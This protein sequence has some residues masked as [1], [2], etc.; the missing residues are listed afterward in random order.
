[1]E[2]VLLLGRAEAGKLSFKPAAIAIV[3]FAMR[4]VDEIRSVTHDRC[5]LSLHHAGDLDGAVADEALL[6]HILSN[7]LSNAVKY[8]PET[9]P[10]SLKILRQG[11]SLVFQVIDQGIGIP[12]KDHAHLF[13]AFH[14]CSN[15]ADQSG[16]GLG[17]VIVNRCV[18]LHGGT[19]A[20][21]TELGKGTSFF[22]TIPVFAVCSPTE[23]EMTHGR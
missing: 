17:L 18:E 8:S 12:E 23:A 7:L 5:P 21:D 22:V 9:S 16:T 11:R 13:E 10:V 14:R 4:M 1:M 19:I 15:V 3:P 6:R 2:Q 20:F